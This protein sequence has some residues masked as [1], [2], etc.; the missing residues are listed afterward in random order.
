MLTQ[1]DP[2]AKF[3]EL[4]GAHYWTVRGYVLR[5]VRPSLAEDVL[6]DTF[7]VAWRR[8]DRVPDDALPWLLGVARRV[9]ANQLR[10][11]LRRGA[12]VRRLR[13]AVPGSAVAW[14]PPSVLTAELTDALRSLSDREREALLLVAWDGLETARAARAAGCSAVAFRARLHRARRRVAEQMLQDTSSR[15]ANRLT[16][17]TP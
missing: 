10:G 4:F 1:N 6:A 2:R 16:E 12:L 7:L 11:E 14:E 5:R 17:G 9:I 3:E 13:G 8:L 15:S